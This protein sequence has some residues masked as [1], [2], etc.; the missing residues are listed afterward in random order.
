MSQGIALARQ[1]AVKRSGSILLYGPIPAD[2]VLGKTGLRLEKTFAEIGLAPVLEVRP[3][4]MIMIVEVRQHIHPRS[5]S[6]H[7]LRCYPMMDQPAGPAV[8]GVTS[9]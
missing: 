3:F 1:R 2:R 5:G 4:L 9:A 7:A 6:R 8:R